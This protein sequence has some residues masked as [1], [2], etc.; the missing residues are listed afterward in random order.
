MKR[1]VFLIAAAL[2]AGSAFGQTTMT[3]IFKI[4]EGGSLP[5]FTNDNT[6]RGMALNPVTGHLLL[7]DR[8]GTGNVVHRLDSAT[9]AEILPPLDSSIYSGGT[10]VISKIAIATDGTIYVCNL[11]IAGANFKIYKYTDEE[12]VPTVCFDDP[13]SAARRGDSIAVTGVGVNTKLL[14]NGFMAFVGDFAILTTTDGNTFT[15]TTITPA[16]LTATN[17]YSQW[18]T[19]GVKYWV[20]KLAATVDG[21]TTPVLFNAL[22]AVDRIV[23]CPVVGGGFSVQNVTFEAVTVKLLGLTP[24]AVAASL[25]DVPGAVF[26]LNPSSVTYTFTTTGLEKAGGANDNGNGTGDVAFD[27]PGK[28]VYFLYTNNSVSGW[29]MPSS[30]SVSDWNLFF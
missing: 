23:V 9:G 1:L 3:Q 17:H 5:W 13:A 28:K 24:G 22:N 10:H 21:V 4:D 12:A 20:S 25:V 11:A 18:D 16:G 29:N 8:D 2:V 14:V 30:T 26:I 27:G 6:C 19:D 7:V 15:A